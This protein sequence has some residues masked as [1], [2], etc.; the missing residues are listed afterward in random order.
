MK[1]QCLIQIS[2][3]CS[4][5]E[6]YDAAALALTPIISVTNECQSPMF[7]LLIG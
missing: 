3:T 5:H 1:L 4:V 6:A 2:F 7:L